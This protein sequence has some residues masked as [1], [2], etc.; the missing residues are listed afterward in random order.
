[1]NK[2]IEQQVEELFEKLSD[3]ID[4][5]GMEG[6]AYLPLFQF[7]NI[8]KPALQERDRIAG[9]NASMHKAEEIWQNFTDQILRDDEK[10]AVFSSTQWNYLKKVLYPLTHEN[11][12]DFIPQQPAIETAQ[13]IAREEERERMKELIEACGDS[14][15]SLVHQINGGTA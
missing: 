2:T 14:I 7:E 9:E 8:V 3:S 12:R 10:M 11:V 13:R 15:E 5:T 4:Y 1:M 6:R